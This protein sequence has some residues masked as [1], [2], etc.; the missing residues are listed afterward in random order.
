[1]HDRRRRSRLARRA[2]VRAI[3]PR[4]TRTGAS[5]SCCARR[6][7]RRVRPRPRPWPTRSRTGWIA[8][9]PPWPALR[10]RATPATS[11]TSSS[12]ATACLQTH[13][14]R[15]VDA[16]HDDRGRR[17]GSRVAERKTAV[18]TACRTAERARGGGQRPPDAAAPRARPAAGDRPQL[19]GARRRSQAQGRPQFRAELLGRIAAAAALDPAT[20]APSSRAGF[21][22][23][24]WSGRLRGRA[25]PYI[26]PSGSAISSMRAPSGSRKYTDTSLWI[27]CA[28][29][30]SC[31]RAT[32]SSQ[33]CRLDGDRDVVQPAEHLGVRADVQPGE[34]EEGQ[35]VAVADVEEEVR[36][37]GVVA[38]LD[39]LGERE[40]EHVLVEADRRLDVAADQRGVVQPARGGRRTLVGGRR[41][42]ARS[43]SRS[44][45]TLDCA[46][47]APVLRADAARSRQI[48]RG[49]ADL[50]AEISNSRVT[51]SLTSTPPASSA[52]FQLTPQSLRLMTTEPSKPMRALPNGSVGRA[53]ELERD[54]DRLGD[55]ADGQV[56]GDL[57]VVAA[58]VLDRGRDE[59]DLRVV[60][61]VEE[62]VGAQ[63]LVALLR[64]ACRCCRP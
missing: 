23:I 49:Q 26:S 42:W 64:C 13:R 43:A 45:M 44:A 8:G 6:T 63:V 3:R 40:A 27:S 32:S 11:T 53:L 50:T 51:F 47:F 4:S 59:G 60:L 21:D 54:R 17:K 12:A 28:T 56:A 9:W 16:A 25:E 20:S 31:S 41:Y 29:P 35:Q 57:E 30:A 58:V 55:A 33:R 62:V 14:H 5:A 34:V 39:Q 2:R 61:D 37:T 15:F 38:V 1:M 19:R 52:A 18:L 22:A 24:D 48:R 10:W 7:C 36:R 46:T